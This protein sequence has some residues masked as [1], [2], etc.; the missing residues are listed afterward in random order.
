MSRGPTMQTHVAAS[1]HL[2]LP[3]RCAVHQQPTS[4][5]HR[6]ARPGDDC[7]AAGPPRPRRQGV[8]GPRDECCAVRSRGL[9]DQPARPQARRVIARPHRWPS[10]IVRGHLLALAA[11][12]STRILPAAANVR[13]ARE[14]AVNRLQ[15]LLVRRGAVSRMPAA[16]RV[17]ARRPL[18]SDRAAERSNEHHGGVFRSDDLGCV[19]PRRGLSAGCALCL[20]V[21]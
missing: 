1:P 15:R 10:C 9:S 19:R 11:T 16:V 20:L 2:L 6:E 13:A 5:E 8:S 12:V 14:H 18:S 3:I 21:L 7:E 4:Q 17:P